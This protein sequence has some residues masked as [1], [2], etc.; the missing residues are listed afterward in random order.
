VVDYNHELQG[1]ETVRGYECYKVKLTPKKNAAVVWGKIIMW[2]SK[3]SFFFIKSEYYDEEEYLVKT[4]LG[5]DIQEMD[6]RQIPTTM[7]IIPAEE[8]GHKTVVN[9][10]SI[11]FNKPI[12]DNFFSQQNMKRLSRR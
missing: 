2:I 12:Q 10:E 11:E 9:I 4:E 5:Y 3:N 7:E 6:G 1:I 8:E